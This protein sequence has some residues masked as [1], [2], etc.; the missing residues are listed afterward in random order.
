M[1]KLLGRD[2]NR[3]CGIR[4]GPLQDVSALSCTGFGNLVGFPVLAMR[5][6][7]PPSAAGANA[8]VVGKGERRKA[9]KGMRRMSL[10][11][12]SPSKNSAGTGRPV[13]TRLLRR[14]RLTQRS[15]ERKRLPRYPLNRRAAGSPVPRPSCG[16]H[17]GGGNILP[18]TCRPAEATVGICACVRHGHPKA[19]ASCP[20]FLLGKA[21]PTMDHFT[22]SVGLRE[23]PIPQPSQ[24]NH[25]TAV[26]PVLAEKYTE[27]VMS[28]RAARFNATVGVVGK[29]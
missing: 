27:P 5:A 15:H 16:T 1:D 8:P 9:K 14:K 24:V 28:P 13:A 3:L 29:G 2:R 7:R 19:V 4:D 17:C 21:L 10:L 18:R 6:L 23:S 20:R 25:R 26:N 11:R 22:H 12:L